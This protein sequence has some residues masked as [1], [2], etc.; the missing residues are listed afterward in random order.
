MEIPFH[1]VDITEE[2]INAVAESM[3]S[4]WLTMGPRTFEFEKLFAAFLEKDE[5][6]AVSSCTAALHLALVAENIGPGDEVIIPI[7]T[8]VATA[9][10]VLYTGATPVFADIEKDNHTIDTN[11]VRNLITENTRAIIPVHYAGNAADMDPI[12]SIAA[13]HNLV[14]IEDAAHAFPATYKGR[15]LGT[16]GD[17]GCF[18]F[19]ATKTITTGE[20]GMIVG[21]N[22]RKLDRIR[23]LR[24][25]GI[26]RDAWNRYGKGGSPVY[27]VTENGYKYNMT[28]TAAA[29]G[30]SQLRRCGSSLQKRQQIAK[31][32]DKY[33]SDNPYIL[34][35]EIENY[36][37]CAFHLYPLKINIDELKIDRHNFSKKLLEK[38]V[39]SSLHFIPFYE[40]SYYKDKLDAHNY[41][42]ADWVYKR[43]ISLPIYPGLS[44]NEVNYVAKTV[45][46]TAEDCVEGR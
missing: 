14:V 22:S 44:D 30:L 24:L 31:I 27:D 1:K 19:Y 25:H 4:G 26:T 13:E 11:H 18:S 8:F 9:E 21:A 36:V 35:Y 7:T 28:D 34:P 39:S 6:V 45:I 37:E 16:I 42:G 3:R 10:A 41:P 12:M 5:A 20:G 23:S 46:K 33:F 17:Y 2:D 43:E 40:F 29:L 32:Y 38:G 15:A